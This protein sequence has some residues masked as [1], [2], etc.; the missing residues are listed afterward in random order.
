M[1]SLS[2]SHNFSSERDRHTECQWRCVYG[3]V[4]THQADKMLFSW[5]SLVSWAVCLSAGTWH[6]Y[7]TFIFIMFPRCRSLDC[8]Y[9][10]IV[11][12][13]WGLL[14]LFHVIF[15][16]LSRSLSLSFSFSFFLVWD[17]TLKLVLLPLLLLLLLLLH[18]WISQTLTTNSTT[19]IPLV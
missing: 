14:C 11:F 6:S 10:A 9:F 3:I 7:N 5:H 2:I 8:D 13:D 4:R 19:I 17:L 15:S 1:K 18:N 16:S 12:H